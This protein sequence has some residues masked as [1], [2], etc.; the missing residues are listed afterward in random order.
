MAAD[1]RRAL[2]QPQAREAETPSQRQARLAANAERLSQAREAETAA[3]RQARLAAD[4]EQHAQ[5]W[6]QKNAEQQAERA[7]Y[8]RARRAALRLAHPEQLGRHYSPETFAMPAALNIGHMQHVCRFYGALRWA[9]EAP[10]FCCSKGKVAPPFHPP[11][12]PELAELFSANS[13]LHREF[14]TNIRRYNCAL[15][16][17]SMGCKELAARTGLFKDLNE[18]VLRLLEQVLQRCNVYIQLL[19]PAKQMLDALPDQRC[20]IVMTEQRRPLTQHDSRSNQPACSEVAVLM[21][22]EPVGR[23]DII[24]QHRDGAARRIDNSIGH[25]THCTIAS[26][27]NGFRP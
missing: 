27:P 7:A 25:A 15:Q 22:N 3:E 1:L 24:V 14:M 19:L 8:L 12:P 13:P 21:P 2:E 20:H 18:D 4:A 9:K 6:R 17:A 16:L 5:A 11:P 23:R 26:S 10:G